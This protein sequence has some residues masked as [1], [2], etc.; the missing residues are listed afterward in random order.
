MNVKIP[1]KIESKVIYFYLSYIDLPEEKFH[2][3]LTVKDLDVKAC[4][5]PGMFSVEEFHNTL[6]PRIIWGVF[7]GM[8]VLEKLS[9]RDLHFH[10]SQVS[11][12]F[13]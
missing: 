7:F 8:Q 1:G 5:E 4:I 13:S 6:N 2:K 3:T 9:K 10:M 12:D 11:F